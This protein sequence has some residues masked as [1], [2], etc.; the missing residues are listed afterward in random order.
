MSLRNVLGVLEDDDQLCTTL[1]AAV[2]LADIE[3]ARLTLAK[4]TDA[5]QGYIWFSPFAYGGLYMPPPLD[6][7][8]E[9]E[10][11]LAKAVELVPD[12]LPVST[13]LLSSETQVVLLKL[14]RGG[15]Y[16][17][18]VTGP[19]LLARCPQLARDL[20]L[21]GIGSLCV[22]YPATRRPRGVRSRWGRDRLPQLAW[23]LA[24]RLSQDA[25]QAGQRPLG[26]QLCPEPCPELG[27][28]GL[29]ELH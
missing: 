21:R 10:R 18:L 12:S 19:K 23:P 22:E 25:D 2:E 1:E 7:A 15:C 4:T 28:S 3:N 11:L 17:M 29:R 20:E 5:G 14:I 27:N 16:D 6:A 8:V 26:R 9:A 24:R 13:V